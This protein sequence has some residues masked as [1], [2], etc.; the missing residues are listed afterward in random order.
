[1]QWRYVSGETYA[2][3]PAVHAREACHQVRFSGA[4]SIPTSTI[5]YISTTGVVS[6]SATSDNAGRHRGRDQ[7]AWHN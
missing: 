1:M 5:R 6:Q 7:E 2:E 3:G 4:S